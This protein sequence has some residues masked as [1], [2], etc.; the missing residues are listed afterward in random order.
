MTRKSSKR[1]SNV[2]NNDGDVIQSNSLPT[3]F[4]STSVVEETEEADN[5]AVNINNTTDTRTTSTKT[6]V[7]VR[8]LDRKSVV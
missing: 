8:R 5:E 1:T 3:A 7:V 6:R 2:K 4:A